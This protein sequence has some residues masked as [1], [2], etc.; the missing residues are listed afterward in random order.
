MAAVIATVDGNSMLSSSSQSLADLSSTPDAS[1]TAQASLASTL[2]PSSVQQSAADASQTS[3]TSVV[4][5]NAAN[6]GHSTSQLA[7]AIVGS[8]LGAA[9]IAF[10]VTALV[11]LA[12]IKRRN[13]SPTRRS[14]AGKANSE[15]DQTSKARMGAGMI[16]SADDSIWQAYLPQ[17][18]D[19]RAM[20]QA[21]KSFFD[22]VELHVDNY[23]ARTRVELDDVSVQRLTTVE[24][25]RLPAPIHQLMNSR[26][27]ALPTIKHCIAEMLITLATPGLV[28][29]TSLLPSRLATLPEKLQDASLPSRESLASRQAYCQWKLLNTY[30]YPRQ[31]DDPRYLGDRTRVAEEATEALAEAFAPWQARPD[32][33]SAVHQNYRGLAVAAAAM[34]V[35]L[36][37]QPSMYE[38]T[39]AGA[40][41]H[42][43]TLVMLPGLWKVTDDHGRRLDLPQVLVPPSAT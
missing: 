27:M 19:D 32:E 25:Q 38:F 35:L 34:G 13:P 21:V 18:A 41:G 20:R 28:A 24:S 11:C 17:S 33:D 12:R 42:S 15:K 5:Y 16:Q 1:S 3:D 23:Y 39:W 37:S 29:T 4:G 9:M 14:R 40:E 7:G 22:H 10:V 26:K 6:R 43:N 36:V 2:Q 31:D 30:L 8:A